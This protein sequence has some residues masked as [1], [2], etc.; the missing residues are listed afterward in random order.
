MELF[1]M[2]VTLNYKIR[3]VGADKNYIIR[4]SVI[5]E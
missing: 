4:R 1:L 5:Y 3:P 2:R